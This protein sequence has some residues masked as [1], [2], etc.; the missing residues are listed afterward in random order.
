MI[1]G[2]KEAEH[3]TVVIKQLSTGKQKELAQ[4]ELTG[5]WSSVFLQ[6]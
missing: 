4:T 5:N 3:G 6:P 1:L 2:S